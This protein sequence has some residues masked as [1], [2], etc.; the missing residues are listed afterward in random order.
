VDYKDYY[1]ILGVPKGA[2]AEEVRSAYRKGA[3]KYHP[4][5]NQSPGAE[6]RFKEINEANEVLKDPEKRK[7]YDLYGENWM[8][9]ETDHNSD[10]Y[11]SAGNNW[12]EDGEPFSDFFRTIFENNF[13]E[14]D[15]ANYRNSTNNYYKQPA[16]EAEITLSLQ[17]LLNSETKTI[18]FQTRTINAQGSIETREKTLNVK[19]PKG[20]TDG[21]T[22]RLP[23][24]DRDEV[25]GTETSDLLLK[26]KVHGDSSFKING[27]NL[28]TKVPVAPWEAALGASIAVK[29]VGGY[30]TLTVPPATVAGKKFRLRGKGLPKKNDG[31]GD[32][33]VEIVIQ[34][35][36]SLSDEERRLFEELSVKSQFD[37][38]RQREYSSV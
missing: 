10:H 2:T 14:S 20:V 5:I 3:R 9:G 34:I 22:I 21:S 29:T 1:K 8:N 19:I 11:S 31:I 12:Q 32:I 33:I 13:S 26:V 7:C 18:S 24:I 4:D 37:P 35:P 6:S 38:R 23:D 28:E 17:E 15:S 16:Y 27:Y 25:N 36:E 30:V